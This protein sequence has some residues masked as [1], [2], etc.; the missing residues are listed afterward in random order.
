[1]SDSLSSLFKKEQPWANQSCL[2]LKKRDHERIAL[3]A[4][5]KR[6]TVSESLSIFLKRV[7]LVI[8][9]WFEQTAL[10]RVNRSRRSSFSCSFLKI[11]GI[12]SLF[13]LYKRATVSKPLPLLFTKERSWMNRSRWSVKKSDR[14]NLLF[15]TSK[16]MIEF[17]TLRKSL[18]RLQLLYCIKNVYCNTLSTASKCNAWKNIRISIILIFKI[19]LTLSVYK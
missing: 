6:V 2:S 7:A 19:F 11:D 5:Y 15:F 1:M 18:F 13:T 12:D 3:V 14:S 10:K 4:L 9:S 16:P 17:P 8:C